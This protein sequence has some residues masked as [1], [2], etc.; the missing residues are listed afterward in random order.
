M[1]VKQN[2]FWKIVS[3][4]ENH[5]EENLLREVRCDNNLE[6]PWIL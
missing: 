4:C 2:L 6:T 1:I 5:M 3:E